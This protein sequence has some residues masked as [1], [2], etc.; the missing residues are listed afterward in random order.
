MKYV[1]IWF[2]NRQFGG[3][4][5]GGWW[6]DTGYPEFIFPAYTDEEVEDL[7]LKAERFI[8]EN[9]E[10]RRPI[11]SVLSEG[12]YSVSV[13]NVYPEAFPAVIPHYE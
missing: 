13:E 1:T 8:T 10:G 11:G 7:K 12:L 2:K 5:E 9:N 3:P 6:Y 4:E